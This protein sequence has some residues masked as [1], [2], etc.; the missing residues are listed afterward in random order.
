LALKSIVGV[1]AGSAYFTDHAQ[2]GF[3]MLV[4]GAIVNELGNLLADENN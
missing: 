1:C 4:A 3:W 2:A